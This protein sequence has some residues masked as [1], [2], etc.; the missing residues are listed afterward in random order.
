VADH[1]EFKIPKVH[2]AVL[3]VAK[4]EFRIHEVHKPFDNLSLQ[5]S[6]VI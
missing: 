1:E 2:K 5:S 6:P 3:H 4:T